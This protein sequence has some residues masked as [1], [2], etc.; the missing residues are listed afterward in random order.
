MITESKSAGVFQKTVS[1][2]SSTPIWRN[3]ACS[4]CSLKKQ[5]G[6]ENWRCE[7]H[8]MAHPEWWPEVSRRMQNWMPLYRLG[9]KLATE[10]GMEYNLH[11]ELED[12]LN[13]AFIQMGFPELQARKN[14]TGFNRDGKKIVRK[15]SAQ[16]VARRVIDFVISQ[17]VTNEMRNPRGKAIKTHDSWLEIS[18]I[19]SK[20][21]SEKTADYDC[22]F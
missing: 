3:C 14:L 20:P 8:E 7:F 2:P 21:I 18:S 4:S 17:V 5:F 9:W 13:K 16:E 12:R 15:E 11:G 6:P 22:P 1:S 19:V 10:F